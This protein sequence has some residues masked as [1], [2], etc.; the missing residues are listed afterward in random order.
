MRSAACVSGS[1][2]WPLS[3]L[4][5]AVAPNLVVMLVFAAVMGLSLAPLNISFMTL[6][7]RRTPQA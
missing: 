7:E 1:L 5:I 3:M 2:C 4:G 6:I